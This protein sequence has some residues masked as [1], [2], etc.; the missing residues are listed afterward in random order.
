MASN[1]PGQQA[2]IGVVE[3]DRASFRMN[4]IDHAAGQSGFARAAF[5]DQSE[6]FALAKNDVGVADGGDGDPAAEQS[7][8]AGKRFAYT[9]EFKYRPA[10]RGGLRWAGLMR[11]R[12]YQRF[13]VVVSRVVKNRSDRA[14]FNDSALLHHHDVIG[15]FGDDAKVVGYEQDAHAATPLDV[16]DQAQ[17]LHLRRDIQ[18]GRRLIGD[19]DRRFQGQ[20]HGDH[21][22]LPL[23]AGQQ[24]RIRSAE[25]RRVGQIYRR[26]Q[27]PNALGRTA[28]VMNLQHFGDL[29]ADAHQGIERGHWL[30]KDHAE[31]TAAENPHLFRR[32][33]EQVVTFEIDR[34]SPDL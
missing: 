23:T 10:G 22:T 12:G 9:D 16:L 18:R 27:F 13:C 21:H 1:W 7:P 20:R 2:K 32:Q 33:T 29:I 26:E 25:T 8:A 15:D 24:M 31:A 11:D 17:D 30:L 4:Q 6:C 3:P 19:Q 34:A 28:Y 14:G 5:A